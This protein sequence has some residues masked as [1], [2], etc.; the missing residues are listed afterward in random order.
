[1]YGY[2]LVFKS[3]F[4]SRAVYSGARTVGKKQAN[5]HF[6]YKSETPLVYGTRM[7]EVTEGEV[8]NWAA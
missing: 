1:M 5:N 4:K 7:N 2:C 6:S 3:G 8:K